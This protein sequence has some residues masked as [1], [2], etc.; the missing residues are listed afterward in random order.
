MLASKAK[1]RKAAAVLLVLA[2]T[3]AITLTGLSGLPSAQA[4]YADPANYVIGLHTPAKITKLIYPTIG[5]PAIVRKGTDFTIEWDPRE[6]T[7][8][9]QGVGQIPLP[10]CTGFEVTATTTNGGNGAI[11][12][13][14]PVVSAAANYSTQWP[15]LKPGGGTDRRVYLVKV[16]VPYSI[17]D[18]LYDL[19]VSCTIEGHTYTDTQTN[20]LD[21]IKQFNAKF[22]FIQMSDIHVYGPENPDASFFYSHSRDERSA[23]RTTY[24]ASPTGQGWGATYLHK[25]IMEINRIRPDFCVFTGDYDFGQRY[26]H[27]N[28]GAPWN[29]STQYEFEQSWFYQEIQALEVPVYIVIGNHDGYEYSNSFYSP[30]SPNDEDWFTNWTHLYSPLYFT[31]NYGQDNK[32]FA[33]N[34]MD[35]SGDQRAL[36]DYLGLILQPIKY[37]GAAQSGGDTWLAGISSQRLNAINLNNFTGQL[38][39]LRDQLAASQGSKTRILAMHH[40]PWKDNGSGGMWA[41]NGS[42]D[43]LGQIEGGLDMGNGPGRL[44]LIKLATLYHSALM[45]SGHDHSD[46]TSEDDS[47]KAL[48]DW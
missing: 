46:C 30:K 2:I 38:G 44:A 29:D 28:E 11:T 21:V 17:P 48:L 37:L 36:Q 25:E 1:P 4:A 39:W 42:S 24:D 9:K 20:S 10:T 12:R 43:W 27:Q 19:T 5:N 47:N 18:D 23:R 41:S 7:F 3:A 26:F 22:N 8:Y 40:D 13:T 33:V 45:I 14:L 35:W 16:N 34:T 31:F 15:L 6:G 32:F